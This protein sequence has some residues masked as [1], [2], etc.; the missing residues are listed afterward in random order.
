[1]IAVKVGIAGAAENDSDPPVTLNCVWSF[2]VAANPAAGTTAPAAKS[3]PSTP[4]ARLD[5]WLDLNIRAPD[6]I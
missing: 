6:L 2:E 3:S 5:L 4:S 1:V